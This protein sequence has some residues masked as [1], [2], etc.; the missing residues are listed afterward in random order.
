MVSEAMT[1]GSDMS[2]ARLLNLHYVAI[3]YQSGS[4]CPQYLASAMAEFGVNFATFEALSA[5]TLQ[6]NVENTIM[7]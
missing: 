3:S 6:M 4:F 7:C 1:A 2:R 5:D